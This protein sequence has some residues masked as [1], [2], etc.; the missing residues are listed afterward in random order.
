MRFFLFVAAALLS[1]CGPSFD[2]GM[3]I[4]RISAPSSTLIG[5]ITKHPDNTGLTLRGIVFEASDG[6]ISCRGETLNGEWH[7]SGLR[8]KYR[9]RFPISCSDG[10]KG[11]MDLRLSLGPVNGI[12]VGKMTDGSKLKVLV[13]DLSGTIGW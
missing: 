8:D 4:D 9:Y 2:V 11:D 10:S 5:S 7:L 1:A 12:G 13:G 6:I 3:K